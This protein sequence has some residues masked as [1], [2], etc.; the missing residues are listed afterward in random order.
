MTPTLAECAFSYAP[1]RRARMKS[2]GRFVVLAEIADNVGD[3][4]IPTQ[5]TGLPTPPLLAGI[6]DVNGLQPWLKL[7]QRAHSDSDNGV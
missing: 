2:P 1:R 7:L 4:P 6:R 5:E 3:Q